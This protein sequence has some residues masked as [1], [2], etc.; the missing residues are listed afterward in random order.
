MLWLALPVFC[1]CSRK[2]KR[3][4][5]RHK[6]AQECMSKTQ[7]MSLHWGT[8]R[9]LA[10]G[11]LAATRQITWPE[12]AYTLLVSL[13]RMAPSSYLHRPP[14]MATDNNNPTL[15]QSAASN[16]TKMI[17]TSRLRRKA[18]RWW[19]SATKSWWNNKNEMKGQVSRN[20]TR[21]EICFSEVKLK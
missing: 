12:S 10:M 9:C 14:A 21:R 7:M 5:K 13:R 20:T 6:H 16:S 18:W 19:W 17:H 4:L 11:S 3:R 1:F 15:S 8:Q 2:S